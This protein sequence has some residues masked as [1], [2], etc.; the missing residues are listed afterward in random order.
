LNTHI[1]SDLERKK[2][3]V[4]VK[5]G[6]RMRTIHQLFW[7]ANRYLP[8][9]RKDMELLEAAIRK[10]EREKQRSGPQPPR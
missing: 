3:E 10:Y 5:S 6:R 9:I 2:L 4:F 7:R 8:T 1:L